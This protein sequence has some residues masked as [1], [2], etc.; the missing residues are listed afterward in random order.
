M[1]NNLYKRIRL[2]WDYPIQPTS[3]QVGSVRIV[4]GT[5]PFTVETALSQTIIDSRE[6]DPEFT[7]L[8]DEF[9]LKE[10][11][12]YYYM[13]ILYGDVLPDILA[14]TD[15]Y[16]AYI[17]KVPV[18][19]S[20]V[21][22]MILSF[23]PGTMPLIYSH[24]PLR[25]DWGNYDSS[26][27]YSGVYGATGRVRIVEEEG[28]TVYIY[29][30]MIES[31]EY[32]GNRIKITHEDGV[33]PI[34]WFYSR[35]Y[36]IE[37]W[38]SE[39]YTGF[40]HRLNPEEFE[41]PYG[42]GQK[43]IVPEEAPPKTTDLS[44]MFQGGSLLSDISK[45]DVSGVTNMDYMFDQVEGLVNLDL[46]KWCVTSI[47]EEPVNFITGDL[48]DKITKPVWGTCPF[49]TVIRDNS[50]MILTGM[51]YTFLD[52]IIITADT[53]LEIVTEDNSLHFDQIFEEGYSYG[54][55]V[56]K[57]RE[58][59]DTT[60]QMLDLYSKRVKIRPATNVGQIV[61]FGCAG[62]TYITQWWVDGYNGFNRILCVNTNYFPA[63]EPPNTTNISNL[64]AYNY[65]SLYQVKDWDF[66]KFTNM[67]SLFRNRIH[68]YSDI[69]H[70]DVSNVTNMS[71][72]FEQCNYYR[73]SISG[74]NVSNVTN[75][76]SMFKR[77]YYFLDN[78]DPANPIYE[79]LSQW[80]VGGI[81]SKPMEFDAQ[82]QLTSATFTP[83]VWGTCPRGEKDFPPPETNPGDNEDEDEDLPM[84][85]KSTM[86]YLY[87]YAQSA[88]DVEV[89]DG[90][91]SVSETDSGSYM[92]YVGTPIGGGTVTYSIKSKNSTQL[93]VIS[94]TYVSEVV[95]WHSKGYEGFGMMGQGGFGSTLVKVPNK[96]PPNT[97]NLANLFK[98]A[99][100][101]NQ[102]ISG[103]EVS[104][105]KNMASMFEE[106]ESFDQDL[107]GWCVSKV[108]AYPSRFA[109]ESL[110]DNTAKLPVWGTCPS[111]L[112]PDYDP[113]DIPEVDYT[114]S[115]VLTGLSDTEYLM[116]SVL[117]IGKGT[118]DLGHSVIGTEVAGPYPLGGGV[119]YAM[120]SARYA[121]GTDPNSVRIAVHPENPGERIGVVTTEGLTTV[122]QWCPN[123]QDGFYSNILGQAFGV[124]SDITTVPEPN[125]SLT[126]LTG[127]FAKTRVFNQDI[128]G[129]NVSNVT[130]MDHM[131]YSAQTF[132]QDLSGWC[133]SNITSEP[134]GFVNE[135]DDEVIFQPENR[136][137]WGTCPNG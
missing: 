94:Y 25:I 20:L 109:Y 78:T 38:Y 127:M 15:L 32:M 67:S 29:D 26:P 52:D 112:I 97:T 49:T 85:V 88:V 12:T 54:Q 68:I 1:S 126:P 64:F 7:S 133:V 86:G 58:R 90:N 104:K 137:V 57:L 21:K 96:A 3:L 6:Y 122:L 30:N 28:A 124:G 92:L 14:A 45:W 56:Y 103:W 19:P 9:D 24:S 37:Q 131:F 48:S 65:N 53:E 76:D 95:Q 36:V 89:L 111:G 17:P 22:P 74:W 114:N 134:E 101:F 4:R 61:N 11:T 136:P 70:W 23:Q 102:D 31:H 55:Y 62:F 99:E 39:G 73:N 51:G 8:Y 44:Y 110:I 5:S 13:I 121:P 63:K 119:Y 128:S 106:A 71:S 93:P 50:S 35:D 132:N 2:Q 72:M 60:E 69:S 87:L 81:T 135:D 84:I 40:T 117:I 75:M 123:G 125:P 33:S 82:S 98:K 80:C 100:D 108:I 79:N 16:T 116:A 41:L 83:P 118:V 42:L 18:D 59:L 115:Y 107:S 129:W 130:N 77:V 43:Y 113:N 27:N 34:D 66:S 46:S 47:T 10:D 91:A 120:Y 105:V